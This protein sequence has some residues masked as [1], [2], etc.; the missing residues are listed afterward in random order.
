M[1]Q[2]SDT[3]LDYPIPPDTYPPRYLCTDTEGLNA[4]SSHGQEKD[5]Y[6]ERGLKGN[7]SKRCRISCDAEEGCY[8]DWRNGKLNMQKANLIKMKSK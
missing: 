3:L 2:P 6:S 7:K 8:S 1:V 5:F 4:I